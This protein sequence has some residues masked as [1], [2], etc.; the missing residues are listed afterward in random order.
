MNVR[1]GVSILQDFKT[2]KKILGSVALPVP[3]TPWAF[4]QL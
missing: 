4:F 1:L 3:V 2:I